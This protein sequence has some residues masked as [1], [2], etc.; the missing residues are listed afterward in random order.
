MFV[1]P[2]IARYGYSHYTSRPFLFE[3][4]QKRAIHSKV[5]SLPFS[6]QKENMEPDCANV[7]ESYFEDEGFIHFSKSTYTSYFA[8]KK[9]PFVH[10]QFTEGHPCAYI[11]GKET[12]SQASGEIL[13]FIFC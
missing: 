3:A 1:N 11:I 12:A 2:F 7:N 8:Y 6:E 9:A 10:H 13:V 4:G 5:N